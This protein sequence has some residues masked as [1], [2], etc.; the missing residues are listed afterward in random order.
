MSEQSV[1]TADAQINQVAEII[2]DYIKT[3][4]GAGVS[5]ELDDM[6]EYNCDGWL[7]RP[8]DNPVVHLSD[9]DLATA[10]AQGQIL[11]EARS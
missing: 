1:L 4:S 8:L 9:T 10:F 3:A 5:T 11:A 6:V 2:A 7:L